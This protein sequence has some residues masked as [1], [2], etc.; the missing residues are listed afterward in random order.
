VEILGLRADGQERILKTFLVQKGVFI[1][2]RGQDP[3]AE[4]LRWGCEEP[5]VIHFGVG[6]GRGKGK[7]PKGL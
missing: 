4:E 6:G 1:I 2:A 5:L 3:W 7:F